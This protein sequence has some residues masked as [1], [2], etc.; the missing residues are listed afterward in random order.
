M[1]TITG[2]ASQVNNYLLLPQGSQRITFNPES[3][4]KFAETVPKKTE[5]LV[6][7][8]DCKDAEFRKIISGAFDNINTTY[9]MEI[10][11][12][13]DDL[14]GGVK[15][16]PYSFI[17]EYSNN[18]AEI[19]KYLSGDI[20]DGFSQI[21]EGKFKYYLGKLFDEVKDDPYAV[22]DEYKNIIDEINKHMSGALRDAT[23]KIAKDYFEDY[24]KQSISNHCQDAFSQAMRGIL[25]FYDILSDY[26][27]L[28]ET[29]DQLELGQT[30][31]DLEKFAGN[32]YK[33]A[34]R[35]YFISL[36]SS[37]TEAKNNVSFAITFAVEEYGKAFGEIKDAIKDENNREPFINA[38]DKVYDKFADW[39]TETFVAFLNAASARRNISIDHELEKIVYFTRK[40]V[41]Y[42]EI[43]RTIIDTNAQQEMNYMPPAMK[44]QITADIKGMF[45][46]AKEYYL[47]NDATAGITHEAI[48]GGSQTF[49]YTDLLIIQNELK[50]DIDNFVLFGDKTSAES[51]NKLNAAINRTF[52]SLPAKEF[53]CNMLEEIAAT[54]RKDNDV[55]GKLYGICAENNINIR[56]KTEEESKGRYEPPYL[57][58]KWDYLE[59]TL[60]ESLKKH[61]DVFNIS[62]SD[63][64]SSSLNAGT[65]SYYYDYKPQ[66]MFIVP[67]VFFKEN[68]LIDTAV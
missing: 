38:L 49:Q 44:E 58:R 17:Q 10:N 2:T 42:G 14:F 61:D 34:T 57:A 26:N 5:R 1:N 20:R 11:G 29:I 36:L 23:I 21:A 18:I 46:N 33:E 68:S 45:D 31:V 9:I 62:F 50:Q 28:L 66:I 24:L 47:K 3:E 32:V 63:F 55:L 7:I 37:S 53:L 30:Q 51:V 22:I 25:S 41:C 15:N 8:A 60:E 4:K 48:T 67:S 52:M 35:E 6:R 43:C 27:N 56:D 19:N 12:F 39:S 16:S 65:E 59:N 64:C 13:Y 54:Y 40:S